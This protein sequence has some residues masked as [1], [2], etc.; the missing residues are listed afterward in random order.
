M[1]W[2]LTGC[3]ENMMSRKHGEKVTW[4]KDWGDM[5]FL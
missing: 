1:V 4:I 3:Y 2:E 5:C